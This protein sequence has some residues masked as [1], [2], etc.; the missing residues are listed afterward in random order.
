MWLLHD[1]VRKSIVSAVP[2]CAAGWLTLRCLRVRVWIGLCLRAQLLD[3]AR[4]Q[5]FR[6]VGLRTFSFTF[7][8]AT[9]YVQRCRPLVA[10][11]KQ[12]DDIPTYLASGV[13]HVL[14]F[15]R[16]NAVS[17]MRKLLV[18]RAGRHHP[19]QLA[20]GCVRSV[21]AAY[22]FARDNSTMRVFGSSPTTLGCRLHNDTFFRVCS[23]TMTAIMFETSCARHRRHRAAAMQ[24]FSSSGCAVNSS[25]LSTR[26]RST[27]W[28][29]RAR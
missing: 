20:I 18:P 6:V 9:D 11:G 26:K 22:I 3:A 2:D 12:L 7:S 27:D 13:S 28:F 25:R 29:T 1:R 16:A 17:R 24:C 14:A 10:G 21:R 4:D 5:N 23:A 8:Q 19:G 15:E